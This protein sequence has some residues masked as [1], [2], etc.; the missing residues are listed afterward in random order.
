MKKGLGII[1]GA[2]GAVGALGFAASSYFF[3]ANFK[4]EKKKKSTEAFFAKLE[5]I[6]LG[7]YV[8]KIK[9]G[10]GASLRT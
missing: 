2:F 6:G 7:S 9:K 5:R 1:L 4:R 10:R 3:G 8:E